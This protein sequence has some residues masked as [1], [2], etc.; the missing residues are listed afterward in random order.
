[1][2]LTG[3]ITALAALL[4]WALVPRLG[5]P[6]LVLSALILLALYAGVL[7]IRGF[8]GASWDESLLLF[9]GSV[10]AFIGFNAQVAY[11][12]MALPLLVLGA[13]ALWR[14]RSA[15]D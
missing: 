10:T 4:G 7:T 3:L 9:N 2:I 8:E 14:A 13:V 5:V 1:L 11:R 6:G 15:H 12:A